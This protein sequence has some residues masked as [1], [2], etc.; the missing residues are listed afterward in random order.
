MGG[1]GGLTSG[2]GLVLTYD[3]RDNIFYPAS[4]GYYE[5]ATAIFSEILGSDYNY[6]KTFIDY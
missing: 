3:S 1:E 5:I 2:L 4:G 6:T